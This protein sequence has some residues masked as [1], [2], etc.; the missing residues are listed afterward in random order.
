MA[1]PRPRRH[2]QKS[3]PDDAVLSQYGRPDVESGQTFRCAP[4]PER[5]TD[6]SLTLGRL[7]VEEITQ[8]IVG[9]PA[10]PF[11]RVRYT[12]AGQLR[13]LGLVVTSTPTSRNP[14]HVSV[15]MQDKQVPWDYGTQEAVDGCFEEEG[16]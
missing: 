1:L 2:A 16:P 8:L 3:V 10:R 5:E 14:N 15:T 13:A 11:D 4:R 12:T 7:T 6:L 9:R